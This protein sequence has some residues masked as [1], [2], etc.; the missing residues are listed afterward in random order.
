M[1]EILRRLNFLVKRTAIETLKTDS[2]LV[3]RN[4]LKEWANEGLVQKQTGRR[5]GGEINK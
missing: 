2:V 1:M 4:A 3:G 5:E